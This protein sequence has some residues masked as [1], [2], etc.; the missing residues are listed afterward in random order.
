MRTY[1][2]THVLLN[3]SYQTS[4]LQQNIVHSFSYNKVNCRFADEIS[5][6]LRWSSFSS[7]ILLMVQNVH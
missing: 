4:M 5:F 3:A 2:K 7:G 6:L 1:G